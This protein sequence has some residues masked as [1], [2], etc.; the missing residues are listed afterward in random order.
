MTDMTALESL[1]KRLEDARRS[2]I[3]WL[4]EHPSDGLPDL[5]QL[6]ILANLE[7]AIASVRRQLEAA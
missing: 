7:T 1:L 5:G 2:Q 6:G 4:S 3:A